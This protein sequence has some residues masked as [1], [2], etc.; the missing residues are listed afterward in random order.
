MSEF[1]KEPVAHKC[2]RK[3]WDGYCN[4]CRPVCDNCGAVGAGNKTEADG[5][6]FDC[7]VPDWSEEYCIAVKKAGHG[8]AIL[9]R[10][11][12]EM[13]QK[14]SVKTADGKMGPA[15]RGEITEQNWNYMKHS[16][17]GDYNSPPKDAA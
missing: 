7:R 12:W 13:A 9:G 6:C 8:P 11:A 3:E 2:E 1:A 17:F 10:A 4:V 5:F 16:V 14:V 15:I